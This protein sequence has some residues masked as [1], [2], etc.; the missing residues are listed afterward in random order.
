MNGRKVSHLRIIVLIRTRLFLHGSAI[1]S[2]S[3]HL[4]AV[5][6]ARLDGFQIWI[7]QKKSLNHVFGFFPRIAVCLISL[8]LA[9]LFRAAAFG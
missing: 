6:S 8:G 3:T 4:P 5:T 2:Y 1:A 7:F 9:L